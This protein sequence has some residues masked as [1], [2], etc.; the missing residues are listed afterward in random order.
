VQLRREDA[1]RMALAGGEPARELVLRLFDQVADQGERLE[2]LERRLGQNSVNSSLPPSSDRGQGPK[3]PARKRSERKQGGQLGHEGAS[4]KLI[5]DPDET[6]AVRPEQCRKCGHELAEGR[7]VGRAARHQVI[8]LPASAVLTTEHQLLKVSCPGCGTHTRAALPDGVEPGAFGPRL[9]ATVVML[10]AML[11]SRRATALVLADMF[12]VTL[13]TGSVEKIL[14]DASASLQEPWEAI[15]RAVQ[16]GDVAHAD[17][18]SWRRA[19]QRMWLWAAL[20]ASAACF[21]IDETRARS[22]AK[23]LLGDF[24]GILISDRYGVYAMLD[25]ARR[26]VC[27]AHLARNFIAHADRDGAAGRHGTVI[28]GLIDQVMILDR[29][30]REDGRQLAWH[31]GELRP[32]HDDLM[33]ALEAG[34]R[35]RTPELATLC[36]NVLDLWPTLWNF[37]EHADIDA[38]NNRAERA[39][40]HAV[41]WRRTSTGT[42]T[43]DGDRFVERILSIRETCR[44]QDRPMHPYLVDVHKARLSGAPIP[45]PL[46]A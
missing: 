39:I 32:V 25:P 24:D 10:A 9:R 4:R 29:H 19:G 3:R 40:R 17:E 35:G 16:A 18:T 8:D 37:T 26:Q 42:Q 1:E 20:S 28:K 21:R 2:K 31:D 34:E 45:T 13:S 22:V 44:C 23:D 36:A 14:Q 41:L 7:V 46:T 33:D 15:K 11:M 5:D 12:G 38:T 27:L 30:A 43:A 6:V